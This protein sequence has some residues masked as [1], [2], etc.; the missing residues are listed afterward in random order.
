MEKSKQDSST[1]RRAI[2]T[3]IGPVEQGYYEACTGIIRKKLY[4]LVH[5]LQ[6][7]DVREVE[8]FIDYVRCEVWAEYGIANRF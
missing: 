7:Y 4:E 5:F 2:I 6:S 1:S 8:F 3:Q